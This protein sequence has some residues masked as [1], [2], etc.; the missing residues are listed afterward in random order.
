M[1][2]QLS[3]ERI[4]S[5]SRIGYG[6]VSTFDQRPEAQLDALREA[7]CDPIFVDNGVSGV[8][9]SRPELDKALA[10]LRPGDTMVCTRLDRLGRSLRNLVDLIDSLGQRKV[11]LV[12]TTQ[13]LDTT[14]PEGRFMFNVIGAVAQFERDLIAARTRE[15]LKA[16][17]AR[18]RLGGRKPSYSPEQARQARR[19]TAEGELTAAEIGR[20]LGVS[21]ATVY[22]M[23][24]ASDR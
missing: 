6:R 24:Q 12:V 7:G 4:K 11:D 16:A 2:A 18:G 15:G 1:E 17:R 13:N 10:Y 9:A 19:M 23:L 22:R 14:T 21:R 3:R 5:M 20:V 8:K